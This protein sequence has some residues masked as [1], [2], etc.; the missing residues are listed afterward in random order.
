MTRSVQKRNELVKNDLAER[1]ELQ[2]KRKI[3]QKRK[4]LDLDGI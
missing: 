1:D 3:E 2:V 4:G